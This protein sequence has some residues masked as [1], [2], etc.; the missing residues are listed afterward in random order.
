MC[1]VDKVALLKRQLARCSC[2]EL[3]I[4]K[5]T[6]LL[7]SNAEPFKPLVVLSSNKAQN[8]T[9]HVLP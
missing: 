8:T 9:Q 6:Y 1:V 5:F 4:L 3:L 7:C 2:F